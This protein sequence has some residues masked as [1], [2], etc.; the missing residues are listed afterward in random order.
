MQ[1]SQ[2]SKVEPASGFE[3]S[4]LQHWPSLTQPLP[5]PIQLP[6]VF[7][8][9][10]NA[11]PHSL[12]QQSPATSHETPSSR[13][14]SQDGEKLGSSEGTDD[15]EKLGSSEGTVDG[16]RD[17]SDD[18]EKLG[19]SEGTVDGRKDGSDDG[20]KLG[21]SEGTVD[22]RRDGSDDGEKLGSSEGTVDGRRDGS[23]DDDGRRDGDDER[24][25]GSDEGAFD[26]FDFGTFVIFGSFAFGVLTIAED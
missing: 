23:D 11:L 15:G 1:P 6:Q 14:G 22:G 3:Q 12:E 13:L 16:R 25:D 21:S 24:R 19:S 17:G 8:K 7:L 10:S 2:Y 26:D 4:L 20:E 5:L 9:V 18:G